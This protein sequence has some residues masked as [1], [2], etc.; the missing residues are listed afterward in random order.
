[1]QITDQLLKEF[2]VS[3]MQDFVDNLLGM[4]RF[5]VSDLIKALM[6]GDVKT[7]LY[8]LKLA[9]ANAFAPGF[10]EYKKLFISL[11]M[12]IGLSVFFSYLSMLYKSRQVSQ[13]ASDILYLLLVLLLLQSFDA[14]YGMVQNSLL[15]MKE[16]ITA[17]IPAYSLSVMLSSSMLA[18]TAS[19]ELLLILLLG[20]D[21]ILL[22]LFLPLS[23][24][25]FLL[26]LIGGLDEK[27]RLKEFLRLLQKILSWGMKLS[28]S[29][30][31]AVS[32]LCNM[33]AQNSTLLQRTLV[34]K[35]IKIM[36]G[37]GDLSDALTSLMLSSFCV[38]RN[39]IGL[40]GIII[41]LLVLIR[42]AWMSFLFSLCI[43][44]CCVCSSILGQKKTSQSLLD[45]SFSV[46]QLF[47]LQIYSLLLFCVVLAAGLVNI[48]G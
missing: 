29:V 6:L 1:M 20:V 33:A 17:F 4:P 14:V 43:R 41:L 35:I 40:A 30:T 46:M 38:I 25:C 2:D 47:K 24:S 7:A 39:G 15:Q 37:I 44:L 23:K 16:F 12:V 8:I 19:Y 11:L 36:P 27:Q 5:H 48:K 28:L 10:L 26:A 9:L 31:I 13:M 42:P 3:G 45:A 34:S 22:K 32:G 18:S 21:Y